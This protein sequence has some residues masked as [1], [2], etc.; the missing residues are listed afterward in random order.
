MAG[1]MTHMAC[2]MVCLTSTMASRDKKSSETRLDSQ[3]L[4][5]HNMATV[6]A[7]GW[8]IFFLGAFSRV[9]SYT[10]CGVPDSIWASRVERTWRVTSSADGAMTLAKMAL[11]ARHAALMPS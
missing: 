1:I 6:A 3:K 11:R 5:I 8:T 4:P 7:M 2:K 9:I 10:G